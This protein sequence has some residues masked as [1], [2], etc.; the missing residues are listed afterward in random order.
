MKSETLPTQLRR[1]NLCNLATSAVGLESVDMPP[2]PSSI[3][4]PYGRMILRLTL[5]A[6]VQAVCSCAGR[7]SQ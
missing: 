4:K 7:G 6:S 5:L 2:S 3:L 1:M